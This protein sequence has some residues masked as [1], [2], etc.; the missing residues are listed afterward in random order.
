[1]EA[2]DV[3]PSRTENIGAQP[4][5]MFIIVSSKESVCGTVLPLRSL[6]GGRPPFALYIYSSVYQKNNDI[7][8]R[9]HL[10][11]HGEARRK[12][13]QCEKNGEEKLLL[14]FYIFYIH[15]SLLRGCL[16]L[17]FS[18]S[19]FLPPVCIAISI[20]IIHNIFIHLLRVPILIA[21]CYSLWLYIAA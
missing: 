15:T 12:G 6:I 17:L 19:F 2:S 20:S 8:I 21:S 3:Y 13:K 10:C 9:A 11:R 1:M 16:S 4:M 18:L 5:F 14:W 7:L